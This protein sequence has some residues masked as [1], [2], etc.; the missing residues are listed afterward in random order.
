MP[1]AITRA[2]KLDKEKG[3][4]SRASRLALIVKVFE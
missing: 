3:S 1:L 4:I 2:A